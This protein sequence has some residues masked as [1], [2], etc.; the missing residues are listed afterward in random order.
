V[1]TDDFFENLKPWSRIKHRLLGKY[2]PPFSAKVASTTQKREIYCVDGFAGAA[3]YDDGSEGSPLLI[4]K[5]SD[6]CATW[7]NPVHL[8]LINVE[9]DTK[10]QGI[11]RTLEETTSAWVQK[12]IVKNINKDFRLALPEILRT[13][14]DAPA[15]FFIDPFGPTYLHF[16]DLK[17]ILT[18]NQRITELIIN[19]DQDGLRRIA[20]A[21]F[22][23]RTNPKA[24][25]TNSQ[26]VSKVIGSDSWKDKIGNKS[27]TSSESESIL[28]EEY[29]GNI[30]KFGYDVVAYPIRE[31]LRANPKY[32][33]VYCTRHRDG[34]AL[35]N[36]FIR[37]EDDLLYD[38]HVEGNLP[39]FASEASLSNAVETRRTS[40]YSIIKNYLQNKR[41]VTRG[42]IRNGLIQQEFGSFHSKDYNEAVRQLIVDGLL[43]EASGKTRINDK[44]VL[45]VNS[46]G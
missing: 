34:V 46:E 13:I 33:F 23:E 22:S 21:A 40:L 9:P 4:A 31:A 29:L 38:A 8:K 35:M 2:L 42:E 30:H 5:T 16:D 26:N 27:L 41:V 15:L 28:L 45:T 25:K 14:G 6:Q 1:N 11:F 17:P 43:S 44:D 36:D 3:R 7:S 37:D 39:L 19:F 12:G 32:Y 18:R 20:D 24:A 10:G